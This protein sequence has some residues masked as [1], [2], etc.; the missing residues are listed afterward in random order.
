MIDLV[1]VMQD[2]ATSGAIDVP[3]QIEFNGTL[4]VR[5]SSTTHCQIC[6]GSGCDNVTTECP[7]CLG[8]GLDHS[9]ELR[10]EVERLR[11]LHD[12]HCAFKDCRERTTPHTSIAY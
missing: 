4:Y 10:A 2:I 6:G 1:K 12:R 3:E 11:E 9:L 7:A 5:A 8:D